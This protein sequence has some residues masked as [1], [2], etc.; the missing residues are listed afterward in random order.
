MRHTIDIPDVDDETYAVLQGRAAAEYLSLSDY[1]RRELD[2]LAS[3]PSTEP[4]AP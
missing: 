3:R 2:E 1:L 4:W